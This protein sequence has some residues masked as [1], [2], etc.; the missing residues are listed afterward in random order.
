MDLNETNEQSQTGVLV[1]NMLDVMTAR[2]QCF[3]IN[4]LLPV[5][6]VNPCTLYAWDGIAGWELAAEV[7]RDESRPSFLTS[8]HLRVHNILSCKWHLGAGYRA[9]TFWPNHFSFSSGWKGG[10]KGGR[11]GI[12]GVDTIENLWS[13][14]ISGFLRVCAQQSPDTLGP[15]I[16]L[17]VA[18]TGDQVWEKGW[19]CGSRQYWKGQEVEEKAKKEVQMAFKKDEG[20]QR[21]AHVL[22]TSDK[23]L[24]GWGVKDTETSFPFPCCEGWTNCWSLPG[25][26]ISGLHEYWATL[27]T[28][29]PCS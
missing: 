9:T 15:K 12:G 23:Q 3:K 19:P 7:E 1:A 4:D 2:S 6:R 10:L 11:G 16:Q 13:L 24:C 14:S 8:L 21:S 28:Y 27:T 17:D 26:K 29:T 5:S 25:I 20:E 22:T 18:L